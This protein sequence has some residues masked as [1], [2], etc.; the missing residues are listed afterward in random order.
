M[1]IDYKA[2]YSA[3]VINDV[4][5]AI[6]QVRGDHGLAQGDSCWL[7]CLSDVWYDIIQSDRESLLIEYIKGEATPDSDDGQEYY[8]G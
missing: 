4:G 2:V 7:Y 6:K 1:Q 3:A 5:D 8:D